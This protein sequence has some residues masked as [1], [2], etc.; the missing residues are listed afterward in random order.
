MVACV[1]HANEAHRPL[2]AFLSSNLTTPSPE[3]GYAMR[4]R[5][6]Y[7]Y[8]RGEYFNEAL[9]LA[10]AIHE[11]YQH[12]KIGKNACGAYVSLSLIFDIDLR[13][14]VYMCV[15]AR[16]IHTDTDMYVCMYVCMCMKACYVWLQGPFCLFACPVR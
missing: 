10:E 16:V 12:G 1:F 5:A 7:I 6:A 11:A 9:V 14:C 2:L 3:Q 4:A 13:M 15:K 8:I